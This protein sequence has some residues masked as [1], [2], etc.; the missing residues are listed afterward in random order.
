MFQRPV[1]EGDGAV[2]LSVLDPQAFLVM[3]P[4]KGDRPAAWRAALSVA[5]PLL[6]IVWLDLVV[7]Q[8]STPMPAG[9]QDQTAPAAGHR[10]G[11]AAV[12][13]VGGPY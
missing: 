13:L 6:A 11:Q 8:F 9:K 10:Q 12:L 1:M 4:T 7:L 2:A 5:I 3:G